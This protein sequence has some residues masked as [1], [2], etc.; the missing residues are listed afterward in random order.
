ML[1]GAKRILGDERFFRY[2]ALTSN[3]Q[4][5]V[6]SCL[7]AIGMYTNEAKAFVYQDLEELMK[8][9]PSFVGGIA[10]KITDIQSYSDIAGSGLNQIRGKQNYFIDKNGINTNLH[11]KHRRKSN[12]HLN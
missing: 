5:F 1:S 11:H 6:K 10:K 9:L 3:C 4:L 2:D 7:E 8:E 12:Q